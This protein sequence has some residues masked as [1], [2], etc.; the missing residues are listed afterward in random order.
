MHSIKVR[1]TSLEETLQH[2]RHIKSQCW[3][4]NNPSRWR[5]TRHCQQA[6][7]EFERVCVAENLPEDIVG[8]LESLILT[9][10]IV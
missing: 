1:Y 9:E 6:V 10:N 2:K 4:R 5:R 3:I 8:I 7:D